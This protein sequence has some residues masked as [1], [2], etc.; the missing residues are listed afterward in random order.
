M[1]VMSKLVRI[2]PITKDTIGEISRLD[3]QMEDTFF[4]KYIYIMPNSLF[5]L[6]FTSVIINQDKRIL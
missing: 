5:G 3:L 6:P 2:A 4:I 1:S